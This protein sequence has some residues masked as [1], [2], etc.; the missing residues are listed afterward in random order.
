MEQTMKFEQ[1]IRYTLEYLNQI[2]YWHWQ[3][4]GYAEHQA[5]DGFE[6]KLRPLVD[7]LVESMMGRTDSLPVDQ[8][9]VELVNYT[10]SAD[11][12]ESVEDI[13]DNYAEYKETISYGDI[14]NIVDEIVQ[15]C[16]QLIYLL[17][18]K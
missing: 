7:S 15:E 12:I 6:Q 5:L 11:I 14:Q 2:K 1:L 8:G 18:L 17:R 16:N 3:T 9:S 10:N 4:K 13:R